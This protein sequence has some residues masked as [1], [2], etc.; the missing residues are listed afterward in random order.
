[1]TTAIISQPLNEGKTY[2]DFRRIWFHTVGFGT[3]SRLCT[4]INAADSREIIVMGF[5]ETTSEN[6]LA[7][8]R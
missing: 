8:V 1:M 7:T 3:S 6:A 4:M 5:V 2:E